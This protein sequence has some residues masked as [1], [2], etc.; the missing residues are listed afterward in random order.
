MTYQIT[1]IISPEDLDDAIK[2]IHE[3]NF[4]LNTRVDKIS[5]NKDNRTLGLLIKYNGIIVGN[6]FYYY[7]P[8]FRYNEK[9]YKVVN[10]ATIYVLKSH[11][12][13]GIS[14]MMLNKTL[15]I[16]KDYIITDYTPVGSIMHI[17]KKLNFG[18]MQNNRSLVFPF[19]L[20]KLNSTFNYFGKL[21]HITDSSIIN[22]LFKNLD[23][24]RQYEI[25]LWRY[26]FK[27]DNLFLGVINREHLKKFSF[28]KIKLKSKRVLWTD[29]E[30]LLAKYA[31]NIALN[32]AKEEKIQFITIDVK[33]KKRPFFSI[34]LKNQF[35][36]YPKLDTKVPT[37]GSE[38]FANNL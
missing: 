25:D 26:N 8:N 38:F 13:K 17:I 29:N 5:F 24:Y 14:K 19:P 37:D 33:S 15:E 31:N 28:L 3:N 20:V 21:D 35:M 6:I 23:Q 7:Q 32:F 11:R 10:F 16:F 27:K 36:M 9:I 22:G 34:K 18:F 1:E 12:G 4:S 2:F 30:E